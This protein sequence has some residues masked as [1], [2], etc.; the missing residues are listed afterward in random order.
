MNINGTLNDL[1]K[2]NQ[3]RN[4]IKTEL[5]KLGKEAGLMTYEQIRNIH[6]HPE[7]F[8]IDNQLATPTMKIKRLA[9]RDFFKNVIENLYAEV[10]ASES[11]L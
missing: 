3:I 2:S 10:S 5:I 1:C 6:L 4:L 11:K 8:T 7:L 9:V